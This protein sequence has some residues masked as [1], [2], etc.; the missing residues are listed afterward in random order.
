[1]AVLPEIPAIRPPG[2]APAASW[3]QEMREAFRTLESLLDYLGLDPS[4]AREELDA[5]PAFPLLATRSFAARM[6]KGDWRDPLLLQIL[7]RASENLEAEGFVPDAVG[8]LDAQVVPGLLHKYAS[9]VLLMISHQCAVHCR[10]CFRREFPYGEMP[11]GPAGWERAWEYLEKSDGVDEI[12]LSGGDPLFLDNLKIERILDRALALPR[13]N[14]IRFHTRLPIV[15]PSRIDP[16]LLAL[17]RNAASEKTIV[18]VV[19]ANHAAEIDAGC[20]RALQALRSAGALMLNQAVLLAGV[21]DDADALADLSRALMRCGTL[22]YY[23]HQL[24]RV[25]GT[26]RF[27]V[28][29]TR[30]LALVESL[31]RKLPGYLVPRYV[32]E[33][34][35][36]AHKT[37]LSL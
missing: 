11:R 37:P 18:I 22:P 12:V 35:G 13:I 17:I 25:A 5:D 7:P 4:Q 30:G 29:E 23:L 36:E 2:E 27:E 34:A 26:T 32:R 1:M 33:I 8:D 3:Q 31:R 16:G 19:H 6:A 28:G 10:Y 24:D 14:T 15:L 21:N 9:R 20:A